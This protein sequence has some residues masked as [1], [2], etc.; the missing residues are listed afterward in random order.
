M[1]KNIILISVMLLGFLYG[2]VD[3]QRKTPPKNLLINTPKYTPWN[4]TIGQKGSGK[5]CQ[6]GSC[7]KTSNC[8]TKNGPMF[9]C[10]TSLRKKMVKHLKKI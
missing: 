10:I 7:L 3:T 8:F 9:K 1:G 2:S 6:N 5:S 4:P